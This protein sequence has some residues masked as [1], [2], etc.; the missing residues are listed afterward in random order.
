MI[1]AT[2]NSPH[3]PGRRFGHL[4][5]NI[6]ESLNAWLLQARD[7]PILPMLEGIRHRLMDLFEKRRQLADKIPPR[8]PLAPSITKEMQHIMNTY[9]RRYRARRCDEYIYEI[10]PESTSSG[11]T[12]IIDIQRRMCDC[13]RWQRLGYPCAHAIAVILLRHGDPQK[14]VAEF[15]SLASWWSSYS[16]VIMP[17]NFHQFN[18]APL[19]DINKY[20]SLLESDEDRDN[21][22]QADSDTEFVLPPST[23][24]PAGRPK[25][26]RIPSENEKETHAF[27]CSCCKGSGYSKRICREA[28]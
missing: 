22:A 15:Y 18:D 9:S 28:I 12:Y 21:D 6:A 11:R 10:I 26:R 4:T 20:K 1:K 16:G 2:N 23:Q 5:S 24:R 25:K 14:Y 3:F 8:T 7:L 19:F 17:P 13:T 27:K